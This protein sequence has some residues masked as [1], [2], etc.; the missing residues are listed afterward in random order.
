MLVRQNCS[1]TSLSLR[2]KLTLSKCYLTVKAKRHSDFPWTKGKST[3]NAITWKLLQ[4]CLTGAVQKVCC[5][6]SSTEAPC[7][8]VCAVLFAL[9]DYLLTAP[10]AVPAGQ[11][12]EHGQLCHVNSASLL[13]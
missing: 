5:S 7:A 4:S 10:V 13:G 11:L 2:N 6:V 3:T 9:Q 1:C 8:T 12:C